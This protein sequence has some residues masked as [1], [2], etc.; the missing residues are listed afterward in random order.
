MVE[1]VKCCFC[2]ETISG[3]GNNPYPAN[4][5]PDAVCCDYCNAT[6][7]IPAR[8][9]QMQQQIDEEKG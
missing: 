8:I 9:K 7:V 1:K 5:E 2:G 4:K 6:V 3:W